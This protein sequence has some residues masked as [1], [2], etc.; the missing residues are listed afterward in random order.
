MLSQDR[1]TP[2]LW[3]KNSGKKRQLMQ[4]FL[5][6]IA[7]KTCTKHKIYLISS[8]SFT[9]PYVASS[10]LLKSFLR[11]QSSWRWSWPRPDWPQDDLD[12]YRS[13]EN[14]K[15]INFNQISLISQNSFQFLSFAFEK[16]LAIRLCAMPQTILKSYL[17][18]VSFS[19]PI[20]DFFGLT[21]FDFKNDLKILPLFFTI[22]SIIVHY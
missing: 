18:T 1:P 13:S 4:R 10:W 3:T 12:D 8:S 6:Q 15:I 2:E 17:V 14:P 5:Y 9:I 20:T 11:L 16:I 7:S 21:W 19:L 22:L